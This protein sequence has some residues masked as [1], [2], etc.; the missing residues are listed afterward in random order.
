MYLIQ[1]LASKVS[2]TNNL[3]DFQTMQYPTSI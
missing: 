2:S 3:E 1:L